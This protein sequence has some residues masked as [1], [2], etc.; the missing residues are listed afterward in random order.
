MVPPYIWDQRWHDR[1]GYYGISRDRFLV[2][3]AVWEPSASLLNEGMLMEHAP[4]VW[5]KT[6]EINAVSANMFGTPLRSAAAA[7]LLLLSA[8]P[9][10]PA[11]WPLCEIPPPSAPPR[12]YLL[13]YGF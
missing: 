8:S 12:A 2:L 6:Q 1:G 13:R 11:S 3:H 7:A 10:R 9:S 4:A 5:A